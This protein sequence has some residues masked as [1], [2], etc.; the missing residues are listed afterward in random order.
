MRSCP[1][2][3]P[4]PSRPVPPLSGFRVPPS[5]TAP[6]VAEF[7][8]R[9]VPAAEKDVTATWERLLVRTPPAPLSVRK[10]VVELSAAMPVMV[11]LLPPVPIL[12]LVFEIPAPLPMVVVAVPVLLIFVV[13]VIV[14]PPVVV[15]L[16]L[17]LTLSLI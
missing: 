10:L 5:K 6:V 17:V 1:A 2:V 4:E 13:P 3:A 16:P 12:I 15:R 8:V 14:A 7:G 11:R 9:P